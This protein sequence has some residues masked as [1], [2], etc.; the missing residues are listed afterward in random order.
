MHAKQ[1]MLAAIFAFIVLDAAM[2]NGQAVSNFNVSGSGISSIS[3]PNVSITAV[4]ASAVP[5]A[6]A[7]FSFVA[8]FKTAARPAAE[9][10]Y[11]DAYYNCALGYGNGLVP[12]TLSGNVWK[13]INPYRQ[14]TSLCSTSFTDP[15]GSTSALMS[16][17]PTPIE[18]P[19]NPPSSQ[20]SSQ[21]KSRTFDTESLIILV[22][23]IGIASGILLNMR[24]RR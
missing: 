24:A 18:Q 22:G 12:F 16:V 20:T 5:G 10:L 21:T 23:I 17:L 14:D 8:V 13:P 7:G 1:A 3:N 9:S 11:L 4:N 15:V 19:F 6:P 2:A